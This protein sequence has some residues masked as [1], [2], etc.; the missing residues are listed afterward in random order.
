[1]TGE[2]PKICSKCNTT[3]MCYSNNCWCNELPM[4]IPLDSLRNCY[5]YN[6]LKKEVIQKIKEYSNNLTSKNIAAIKALGKVQKHIEGI[7]YYIDDN[8]LFVFTAWYHLRR[9]TCCE[10]NCKHCPY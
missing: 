10:N 5:C 9:G 4:L 1:M 7:D 3:F 2:K 6:C 8:K